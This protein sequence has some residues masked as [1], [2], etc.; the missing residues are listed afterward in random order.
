MHL[1]QLGD[2]IIS[3]GIKETWRGQPWSEHC[4]E[5][6]Y[7]D[8]LLDVETLIKKFQFDSCITIHDYFDPKMGSELG[9]VCELCNDGIMGHHPK[10]TTTT[11]VLK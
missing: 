6:I 9:F 4:R 5:W 3:K 10:N 2:Y 1:K 8:C 7:F 11:P